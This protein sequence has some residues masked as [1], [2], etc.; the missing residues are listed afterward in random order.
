MTNN[1]VNLRENVYNKILFILQKYRIRQEMKN[2]GN[3]RYYAILSQTSPNSYEG[4][5]LDPESE[6][7]E[8]VMNVVKILKKIVFNFNKTY[9]YD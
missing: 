3:D 4:D 8:D 6:I 1:N 2:D 9:L 7:P 5:V